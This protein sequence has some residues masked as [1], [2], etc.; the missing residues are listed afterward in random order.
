MNA[1]THLTDEQID[2]YLIGDLSAGLEA[3]FAVCG[4]CQDRVAAMEGPIAVF[5]NVSLAWSER[6]SATLPV[7]PAGIQLQTARSRRLLWAATATTAVAI[8]VAIPLAHHGSPKAAAQSA[9][10]ASTSPAQTYSAE[11]EEQI[12]Q[13]NQML[14][15]IDREIGAPVSSPSETFGLEL[16]G[17]TLP[18]SRSGAVQD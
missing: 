16:N 9:P 7:R 18:T 6:Q 12:A 11:R 5:K 8:S 15:D 17:H 13:D 10:Q 3:H 4:M 2:D 1:E 14:Q